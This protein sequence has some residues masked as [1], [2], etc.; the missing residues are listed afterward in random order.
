MK[1]KKITAFKIPID[2]SYSNNIVNRPY[3][4]NKQEF[5]SKTQLESFLNQ[6]VFESGL[7]L[8]KF[9]V[10]GSGKELV[11]TFDR[12]GETLKENYFH[13]RNNQSRATYM[14]HLAISGLDH[15][16]VTSMP[17]KV[18]VYDLTN[19]REYGNNNE[20]KDDLYSRYIDNFP[21]VTIAPKTVRSVN[22]S[23]FNIQLT[24]NDIDRDFSYIVIEKE[25]GEKFGYFITSND[26]NNATGNR[27]LMCEYDVVFNHFFE[28]KSKTPQHIIKSDIKN[29]YFDEN[30]LLFFDLEGE[31]YQD[32]DPIARV[33]N[34][35][36]MTLSGNN[37]A[38]NI[39]WAII[40]LNEQ[41]TFL[42]VDDNE[43][44][45][46]VG[47]VPFS[48][49][50]LDG[51]YVFC[52]LGLIDEYGVS[53]FDLDNHDVVDL[54]GNPLVPSI[55]HFNF[56]YE[57][58][59]SVQYTTHPPFEVV[60]E[61]FNGRMVYR[62]LASSGN[63]KF[64]DVK[65]YTNVIYNSFNK[66]VTYNYIEYFN[67]TEF[68]A[69]S[70]P[71]YFNDDSL[72]GLIGV[73]PFTKH[74]I[75][76]GGNL[77]PLD[78]GY[79]LHSVFLNVTPNPHGV[80]TRL[81]CSLRVKDAYNGEVEILKT[82]STFKNYEYLG[83]RRLYKDSYDSYIR[84]NFNLISEQRRHSL[85]LNEYEKGLLM[86]KGVKSISGGVGEIASNVATGYAGGS[87]AGAFGGA[88]IGAGKLGLSALEIGI[89]YDKL[90][91]EERH[92]NNSFRAKALDVMNQADTITSTSSFAS[93]NDDISDMI[94]FTTQKPDQYLYDYK[95]AK[96]RV[97]EFGLSCNIYEEMPLKPETLN[98]YFNYISIDSPSFRT[99]TNSTYR[100]ALE[101]VFS[102]GTRLWYSDNLD[103]EDV[104]L[105]NPHINNP[106]FKLE[107]R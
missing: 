54:L 69:I 81:S 57:Y 1:F 5:T 70:Q 94:F 102:N 53:Y 12:E 23:D 73:Y 14:T 96:E 103:D 4:Y 9:D 39:L 67:K 40:S 92:I 31:R 104:K 76:I 8:A 28:L 44:T 22:T 60:Y 98:T 101:T 20:Y 90:K 18:V 15:I 19:Y 107:V 41:P 10:Y 50:Y 88:A 2:N 106:K 65:I 43:I 37:V 34:R 3:I 16:Y 83:S 32:F 72:G 52:P 38:D 29:D 48:K 59:D 63:M 35:T 49:E 7:S 46:P 30:G 77:I 74:S 47:N 105:L 78:F 79:P 68:E 6:E 75:E 25:D 97:N 62:A 36:R 24:I 87:L 21:H 51:I 42:T 55:F 89:G 11:L 26:E 58:V 84:N 82:A 33:K 93:L 100:L 56:K 91:E 27:T 85:S 99:I 45:V 61:E 86:V 13:V 95:S 17:D 80:K 64:G 71:S 66:D